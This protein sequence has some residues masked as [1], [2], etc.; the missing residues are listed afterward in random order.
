LAK[1]E[2]ITATKTFLI[3]STYKL[4]TIQLPCF[5][6]VTLHNNK[7]LAKLLAKHYPKTKK[8]F[9]QT[10]SLIQDGYSIPDCVANAIASL[11]YAEKLEQ[12]KKKT[13]NPWKI[14]LWN[15]IG[16]IPKEITKKGLQILKAKHEDGLFSPE[17][18]KS[19][20]EVSLKL[21]GILVD[22]S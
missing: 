13:K 17:Y 22:N 4:L 16:I 6:V 18:R 8:I 14:A 1:S 11:A 21:A 3:D 12:I 15:T 20:Q 5:G 2:R 10:V 9:D 19:M 7:A